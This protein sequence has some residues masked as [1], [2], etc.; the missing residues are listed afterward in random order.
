MISTLKVESM[1]L[2]RKPGLLIWIDFTV[3]FAASIFIGYILAATSPALA[4]TPSD[5][6]PNSKVLEERIKGNKAQSTIRF[7]ELKEQ[8]DRQQRTLQREMEFRLGGMNDRLN[9]Y[10]GLAGMFL[11]ILSFVGFTTIKAWIKKTIETKTEEE[12]TN[13]LTQERLERLIEEKGRNAI[14]QIVEGAVNEAKSRLSEID[15]LQKQYEESLKHLKSNEP[16]IDV[17]KPLTQADTETLQEFQNSMEK[18]KTEEQYT[19]DDWYYKGI[20]AYEKSEFESAISSWTR[21]IKLNQND[22]AVCVYRGLAYSKVDRRARAIEDYDKAIELDPKYALA[23]NNRGTSY[24]ALKQHERAIEDYDKAIE[25]DPKYALA[26]INRGNRYGD[27]KQ[28]ERAIEDYDKAIELDPKYALAYNNRGTSYDAL[29][30]Q[31]RAIEDYDKAIELDPKEALTYLNL[32]ELLLI[33]GNY[34]GSIKA[35]VTAQTLRLDVESGI[36]ALL[37]RWISQTLLSQD[38]KETSEELD[39]A[40]KNSFKLTF[41]LDA[42]ESYLKK[43][44]LDEAKKDT[45]MNK[46]TAVKRASG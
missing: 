12:V 32:G 1:N 41:S 31:Q 2:D 11:A 5:Q 27:L 15:H 21:A 26:Y 3:L 42:L 9:I 39:A 44:N 36:I 7:Q 33:T 40:L 28:H 38:C 6:S 37:L 25:L 30:Q 24:G 14:D 10:F 19:F 18:V 20:S 16:V 17:S 13:F 22:K 35:M 29:K 8:L 45:I 46:I 43:A 34:T 23:Y 4:Q